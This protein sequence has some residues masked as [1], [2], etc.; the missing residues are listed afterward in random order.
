MRMCVSARVSVEYSFLMPASKNSSPQHENYEIAIAMLRA[1][2]I[3]D[4]YLNS[5]RAQAYSFMTVH[6][7]TLCAYRI[8]PHST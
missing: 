6:V 8:A 1:S 4:H 5:T 2:N 3:H 7:Q